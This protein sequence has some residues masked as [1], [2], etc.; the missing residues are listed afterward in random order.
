MRNKWLIPIIV[1]A[2]AVCF[3]Y[4]AYKR[5]YVTLQPGVSV[6]PG[7]ILSSIGSGAIV[8][9]TGTLDASI[10][11]TSSS[12]NSL[13]DVD[14]TTAT[15]G[16]MPVYVA[17]IWYP[18]SG[19]GAPSGPAGGELGGTYPNPTVDDGADDT[20]LHVDE[21]NEL[22]VVTEKT[23]P[24]DGDYVILEDS[25]D[26]YNKKKMSFYNIYFHDPHG[27][28]FFHTGDDSQSDTSATTFQTKLSLSMTN[29]PTG[30]YV[31]I[32]SYEFTSSSSSKY[33]ECKLEQTT[34]GG[35]PV[36]H[37]QPRY[38]TGQVD[39]FM[40]SA[41]HSVATLSSA[42]DYAWTLYWKCESATATARIRRAR[43]AAWRFR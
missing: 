22:S 3:S 10:L 34:N 27:S 8:S 15:F 38:V 2:M 35:S 7:E 16:Q 1:V 11:T 24:A 40:S 20:A 18:G 5:Q 12:F 21:P 43:I 39:A 23:T 37:S 19:G 9:G 36:I 26:G 32:Y 4:G 14:M 17:G 6:V 33:V 13:S 29:P 41:G 31:I 28:E 42:D 25:A 30:T